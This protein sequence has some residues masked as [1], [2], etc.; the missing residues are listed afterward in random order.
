MHRTKCACLIKTVISSALLEAN[1]SEIDGIPFAFPF[2]FIPLLCCASLVL[3]NSEAVY[4]TCHKRQL[5][6]TYHLQ[7]DC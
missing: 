3:K 5:L 2:V 4:P 1:M 6:G 7:S